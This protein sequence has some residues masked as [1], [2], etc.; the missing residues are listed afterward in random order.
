MSLKFAASLEPLWPANATSTITRSRA[1]LLRQQ[2]DHAA[3]GN[4]VRRPVEHQAPTLLEQI[5]AGVGSSALSL[6]LCA[7]AASITS[8]LC[9]VVSPA[10]SRNME[11]NPCTMMSWY[12]MRTSTLPEPQRYR[13]PGRESADLRVG[14]PFQRGAPLRRVLGIA[15]AWALRL[16]QRLC[17]GPEAHPVPLP[18]AAIGDRVAPRLDKPT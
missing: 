3:G 9:D 17:R 6:S 13:W 14:V 7:N 11:R 8:R 10:Q 15:P 1:R 5:A 12:P 18:A 4:Q 16:D 2:P